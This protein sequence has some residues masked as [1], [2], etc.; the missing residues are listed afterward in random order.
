MPP[1]VSM[2]HRLLTTCAHTPF[3]PPKQASRSA[4]MEHQFPF[5]HFALMGGLGLCLPLCFI[6]V[7]LWGA[8]TIVSSAAVRVLYAMMC[9]IL[10][11]VFNFLLDMNEPFSGIYAVQ[12]RR[13]RV[14]Q[15]GVINF[16]AKA[17]QQDAQSFDDFIKQYKTL[18]TDP[19]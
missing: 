10:A 12:P 13:L 8:P 9:G 3:G 17:D 1:R 5:A 6:L 16:M 4:N 19:A 2:S 7:V 15:A 11:A 14:V 18:W